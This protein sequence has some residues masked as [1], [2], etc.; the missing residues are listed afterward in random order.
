MGITRRPRTA[1]KAWDLQSRCREI[2]LDFGIDWIWDHFT[3]IFLV[4]SYPDLPDRTS[5]ALVALHTTIGS[6]LVPTAA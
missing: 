3:P 6:F 1:G 5:R 4:H 2:E